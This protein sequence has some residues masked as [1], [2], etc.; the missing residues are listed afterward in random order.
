VSKSR[1]SRKVSPVQIHDFCTMQGAGYEV[2]D[3]N[4][5]AT[6]YTRDDGL[7]YAELDWKLTLSSEDDASVIYAWSTDV[8]RKTLSEIVNDESDF[9]RRHSDDSSTD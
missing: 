8:K 2:L 6:K 4:P 5:Q 3:V 1:R 7:I 9:Q